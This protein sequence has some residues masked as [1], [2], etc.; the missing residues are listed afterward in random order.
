MKRT[1]IGLFAGLAIGAGVTNFSNRQEHAADQ[2]AIMQGI[3]ALRKETEA[4]D[5]LN[6]ANQNLQAA[7]EVLKAADARLK[8]EMDRVCYGGGR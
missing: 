8:R 7:D 4:L 5:R 3:E 1:L 6:A 2:R